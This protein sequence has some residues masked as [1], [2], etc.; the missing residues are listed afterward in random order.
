MLPSPTDVYKALM[1]GVLVIFAAFA[2][3]KPVVAQVSSYDEMRGSVN[4]LTHETGGDYCSSVTIEEGVALTARHCV[5]DLPPG[6]LFVRQGDKLLPVGQIIVAADRDLARIVVA[7]LECPCAP[8]APKQV[9]ELGTETW[10]V[11]F[12]LGGEL[13]VTTGF[14]LGLL[15]IEAGNV[16]SGTYVATTAPVRPGNSGGG[17]FIYNSEDGKFYLVGIA[18][19]GA[20][21]TVMLG[22][23]SIIAG[24]VPVGK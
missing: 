10:V 13:T 7:G 8:L 6:K 18:S 3:T 16:D 9:F 23:R 4:E 21:P 22:G 5:V 15:Q 20:G 12:P 19:W 11:G 2:L 14:Y 17:L 24:F 1:Y